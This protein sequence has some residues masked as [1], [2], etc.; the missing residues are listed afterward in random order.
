VIVGVGQRGE[1][2]VVLQ[3]IRIELKSI[4]TRGI[5]GTSVIEFEEYTRVV[6]RDTYA[7]AICRSILVAF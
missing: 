7:R 1:L 4:H 2:H 3:Y 5:S 6:S